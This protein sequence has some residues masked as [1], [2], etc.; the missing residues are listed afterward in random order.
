MVADRR[1]EAPEDRRET[2]A[3]LA[4]IGVVLWCFDALVIFFLPAGFRLGHQA[5]FLAIVIILAVA[6]LVLVIS[7]SRRRAA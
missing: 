1:T 3:A 4:I 2:G 5:A 7:G 6:G